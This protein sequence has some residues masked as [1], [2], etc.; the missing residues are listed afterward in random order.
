MEESQ[1]MVVTEDR[2]GYTD[3]TR[4]VYLHRKYCSGAAD[5]AQNTKSIEDL[6]KDL[7]ACSDDFRKLEVFLQG[8][9]MAYWTEMDDFILGSST[10]ISAETN[11]AY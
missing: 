6:Q 2:N 10:E 11:P 4:L 5:S 3:M 7:Y 9:R 8:G 1:Q